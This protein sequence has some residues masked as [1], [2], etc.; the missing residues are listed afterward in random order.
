VTLFASGDSRTAAKLVRCSD[1]ALRL[2]PRVKER[3][4][5][6]LVML[7][8]VRRRAAEFDVLHFHI[9][10][11]HY[12]LIA[13][14]ADRTVTTLHGRLHLPDLKPTSGV[15]A[16]PREHRAPSACAVMIAYARRS[17]SVSEWPLAD[18]SSEFV[19]ESP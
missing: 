18:R 19:G 2:N 14:F 12:P 8:E 5:Y 10:L 15:A 7:N 17:C 9:D 4:P 3:D 11:L 13:D 1:M 6:H 16:T